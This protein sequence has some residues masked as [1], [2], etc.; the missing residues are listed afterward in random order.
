MTVAD[1]IIQVIEELC[2]K[3]GIAVDY[4]AEQIMPVFQDLIGRY[5]NY[6]ILSKTAFL[7]LDVLL[8]GGLIFAVYRMYRAYHNENSQFYLDD[9]VEIALFLFSIMAVVGLVLSFTF[10]LMSVQQIIQAFT[11]PEMAFLNGIKNMLY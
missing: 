4:T 5:S 1:Q 10:V 2:A 6:I 11:I 8:E 9:G 7:I 3:F